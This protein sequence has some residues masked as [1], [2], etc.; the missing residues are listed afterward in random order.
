[1]VK[2]FAIITKSAEET[3]NFGIEFA[4]KLKKGDVIALYGYL[5]SGKTELAKGIC[6][7]LGV[8]QTVS[9]PTFVIVN[10]YSSAKF[11]KIFHL[12]LYRLKTLD[13]IIN[14]GFYDYI[15]ENM[16]VLIEW[17]EHVE[18]LLPKNTIKIRLAY[19]DENENSRW[20]KLEIN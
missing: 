14:I 9:S 10:E 3:Q 13:D 15:N 19:T 8:T 5:G 7:G 11:P 12:D 6:K 1:M 2:E 17:P 4:K 18:D 16:L 20:I